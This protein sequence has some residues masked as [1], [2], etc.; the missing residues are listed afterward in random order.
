M[1]F[2]KK[3]LVAFSGIRAIGKNR[4]GFMVSY[5][6]SFCPVK[7]CDDKN[8]FKS[9]LCADFASGRNTTGGGGVGVY[10]YFV[11]DISILTGPV[12]FNS[13]KIN[14]DWKW[15]LQVDMSFSVFDWKKES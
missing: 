12:W 8:Y 10:Y 6:R 3:L 14:G 15:S 1:K 13:R 9:V 4:Q 5:Q 7:S 11:P 2:V